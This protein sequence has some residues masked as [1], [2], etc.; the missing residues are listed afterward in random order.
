[1]SE[2]YYERVGEDRYRPTR[3]VQG[4]WNDHEQHLAPVVGLLAHVVQRH[5]PRP[6]LQTARISYDVLGLIPLQES[7]VVVRTLRPGRTIELVEAALEVAGRTVVRAT[8]WRLSRQDTSSVEGG[9]PP[10]LPDAGTMPVWPVSD[11]WDGGYIA[12]LRVHR[13]QDAAPGRARSWVHSDVEL[14]AGEAISPTASFLRLVDTANGI[15]TLVSPTEWMFPNVDLT[16]HLFR[17]PIGPWVGFDT[18]VTFGG[19][20]L[21]LTS[22][23]LHDERG[24]VGRA[25]QIL[26]VRPMP[27]GPGTVA[28]EP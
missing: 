15:A 22:S 6:D 9:Y 14:V 12:S 11:I 1:M 20:G 4:A 16:V 7:V 25:E 13:A 17:Q 18:S 2:F 10:A 21:G 27:P 24:P 8:A 5:D 28:R 19:G 26:T 3:H 23:W